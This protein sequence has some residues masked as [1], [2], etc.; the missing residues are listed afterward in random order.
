MENEIELILL[1]CL[2]NRTEEENKRL[3]ALLEI[4]E[5]WAFITGQLIRHRING[6]FY[7]SLLPEQKKYI[8][9]KVS[10]TFE[11]LCKCYKEYNKIS[12]EFFKELIEKTDDVGINVA[13]LKGM[14]FNTDLYQLEARRSNDIDIL[15]AEK[16]LKVFDNIMRENGFIQSMNHGRTEATKRE[17]MIQIMNYHDLVPY[18]KLVNYSFMDYIK[19]DVN[20][21]F[22]SKEHDITTEVLN[23]GTQDY[24][25][26]GYVVR[27]L[28]KET[29]LLHLCIHFYREA[30]NSIWTSSARDVD[31][32]KI[33]DI[34]NTLR[35]YGEI[36]SWCKYVEKY[37]LNKQCYFTFN[38]LNQFYPNKIYEEVMDIIKPQDISFLNEVEVLGGRKATREMSFFERTFDMK[39]GKNFA[40]RNME[41]IF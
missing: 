30:T 5:D 37:K 41:K 6:N 39:Y 17:K 18:Y 19:V 32:Y 3:N 2:V 22:D 12:L 8:I 27:G 35:G 10:Q 40:N 1:G 11:I 24:Y 13:G 29:H 20:F 34:E 26:N 16:D 7:S 23:E 25:G 14:V 28:K 31:L 38:Y 9:G 36:L 33:V 15:V 21:H 4:P